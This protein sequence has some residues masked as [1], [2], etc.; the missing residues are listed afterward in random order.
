MVWAGDAASVTPR[1][2]SGME[3]NLQIMEREGGGE[4]GEGEREGRERWGEGGGG[5]ERVGEGERRRVVA[6]DIECRG[7][8]SHLRSSR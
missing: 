3:I 6:N 2:C 5:R 4:E 8:C 1:K 7:E